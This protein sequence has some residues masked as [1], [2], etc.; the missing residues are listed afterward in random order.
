MFSFESYN[1]IPFSSFL[2]FFAMRKKRKRNQKKKAQ[3]ANA[4][5]SILSLGIVQGVKILSGMTIEY[6]ESKFLPKIP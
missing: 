6:I 4:G 3:T 2:F 5:N 1:I